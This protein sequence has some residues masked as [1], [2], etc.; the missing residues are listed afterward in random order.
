LPA[1]ERTKPAPAAPATELEEKLTALWARILLCDVGPEENFF[2][3]GGTSLQLLEVHA[4]LTKLLG[5]NL[6]V[7]ELFD[8]SS[9]RALAKRLAGTTSPDPALAGAQARADRQKEAFARQRRFKGNRQ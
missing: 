1:P 9:V 4:E 3:L 2:D 7:T 5:R 6:P 8:Y